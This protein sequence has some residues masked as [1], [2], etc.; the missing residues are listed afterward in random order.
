VRSHLNLDPHQFIGLD[1]GYVLLKQPVAQDTEILT[2]ELIPISGMFEIRWLMLDSQRVGYFFTSQFRMVNGGGYLYACVE[3]KRGTATASETLLKIKDEL[4]VF[5][6][7]NR[8]TLAICPKVDE[9]TNVI[10]SEQ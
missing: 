3:S 10:F 6:F 4:V 2:G 5:H 8:G 9:S 1:A 7:P